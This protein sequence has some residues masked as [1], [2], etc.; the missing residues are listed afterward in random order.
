MITSERLLSC[1]RSVFW[2]SENDDWILQLYINTIARVVKREHFAF[3][4][5]RPFL[6][7]FSHIFFLS[8]APGEK[9][10]MSRAGGTKKEAVS[11][12][13]IY[14]VQVSARG[15]TRAE[16]RGVS[17]IRI[18]G[19]STVTPTTRVCPLY[20][21]CRPFVRSFLWQWRRSFT[22]AREVNF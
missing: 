12:C 16:P 11:R 14:D 4:S 10:T 15:W 19:K 22:S 20:L 1:I 8:F 2:R 5:F 6:F 7:P 18:V 21:F 9:T 13:K 3:F 17:P